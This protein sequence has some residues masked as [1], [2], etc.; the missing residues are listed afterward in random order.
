MKSPLHDNQI[1]N[2][3]GLFP[4]KQVPRFAL[5]RCTLGCRCFLPLVDIFTIMFTGKAMFA[6]KIPVAVIAMER[7]VHPFP[8]KGTILID[9]DFFLPEIFR[10]E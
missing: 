7:K 10:K 2:R 9:R 6:T 8:T 5:D 3:F 1:Q 4:Y